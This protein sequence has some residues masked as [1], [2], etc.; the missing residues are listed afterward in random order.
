MADKAKQRGTGRL[1][2]T[3]RALAIMVGIG[4]VLTV[5]NAF[6]LRRDVASAVGPQSEAQ[7]QFL[8]G[9]ADRPDIAV[10]FK[11]LLPEQRLAMAQ[12]I[13]R[14]DDP[15]L[16]L[17]VGKLLG[18]FDPEAR[19]ALTASMVHLVGTQP[20]PV[21]QQLKEKG[22]FQQIGVFSA[23]RT[24][25]P[26]VLPLVAKQLSVGDARPNVIA[27]MVESGKPSIPILIPYLDDASNDVKLAAAEALGKLRAREA[28][29]KLVELYSVAEPEPKAQYLAALSGIGDPTQESLMASILGNALSPVA[30]RA[31]AA[32]GLGRIANSSSV[33]T[34][35]RYANEPE[36]AVRESAIA[37]LVLAGDISLSGTQGS[38]ENRL[39]V[40]ADLRSA[41]A[42]KVIEDGLKDPA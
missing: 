34:L 24:A 26:S 42:D 13:G 10:F 40:A 1:G 36:T 35:W 33:S 5:W 9:A 31:S 17:L 27:F 22:S 8:V 29:S 25:G 3:L 20:E 12:A 37:G 14:Y 7:K 2:R 23:L 38:P 11:N 6:N 18:D 4:I 32:L 30:Q 21:A 19:K 39:S 16:P 15:K 41:T 28:T